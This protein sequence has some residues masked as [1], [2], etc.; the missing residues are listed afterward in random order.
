MDEG[1]EHEVDLDA[2]NPLRGDGDPLR[3]ARADLLRGQLESS[4]IAGL[5]AL[6]VRTLTRMT[7]AQE[8]QIVAMQARFGSVQD[9]FERREAALLAQLDQLQQKLSDGCATTFQSFNDMA[10]L[11]AVVVEHGKSLLD[12]QAAHLEKMRAPV[13]PRPTGAETTADVFKHLI[14]QMGTLAGQV[15]SNNPDMRQRA[16]SLLGAAI[17]KGETVTGH[18]GPMEDDRGANAA[19]APDPGEEKIDHLPLKEVFALFQSLPSDMIGRF[20]TQ[21]ELKEPFQASWRQMRTL[22]AEHQKGTGG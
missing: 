11:P 15:F 13:E 3:Q 1:D 19:P 16:Q 18:A 9:R 21:L 8:A 14:S 22:L 17:E 5:S 7:T 6:H 20:A 12:A 2:D 4:T 10:A